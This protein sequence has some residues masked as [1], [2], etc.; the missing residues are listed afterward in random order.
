MYE[1]NENAITVDVVDVVPMNS[2]DKNIL[3]FSFG[4]R[5]TLAHTQ[6][7]ASDTEH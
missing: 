7:P 2:D 6:F 4:G 1:I 3:H 5:S